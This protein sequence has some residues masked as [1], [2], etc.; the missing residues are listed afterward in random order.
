MSHSPLLEPMDIVG[1]QPKMRIV[2]GTYRKG[3]D[4]TKSQSGANVVTLLSLIMNVAPL[5]RTILREFQIWAGA[6]A[7]PGDASDYRFFLSFVE[8]DNLPAVGSMIVDAI[9]QGRQHWENAG[10]PANLVQT[11]LQDAVRWDENGPDFSS[12]D[13]ETR[14]VLTALALVISNDHT[15]STAASGVVLVDLEYLVRTWG[16][17][18]NT[19]N[20]ANNRNSE[21]LLW[22]EAEGESG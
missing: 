2:K 5:S 8:P 18:S 12:I 19:W 9:W 4:N 21:G 17:D 22:E 7:Q 11:F 15:G 3:F 1:K 10:T 20:D 14:T 16:N 6:N 13:V